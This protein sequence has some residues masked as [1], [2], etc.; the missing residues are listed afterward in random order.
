MEIFKGI[1]SIT[2]SFLHKLI[3]CMGNLVKAGHKRKVEWTT[4]QSMN[5][6]AGDS[7]GSPSMCGEGTYRLLQLFLPLTISFVYNFEFV[8]DQFLPLFVA[9]QLIVCIMTFPF[10]LDC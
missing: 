10:C 9:D 8:L 2:L 4:K 3:D 5:Y 7:W 6:S 1:T